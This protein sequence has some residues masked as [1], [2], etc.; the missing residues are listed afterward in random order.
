MHVCLFIC[1]CSLVPKLHTVY[2]TGDLF[3]PEDDESD[4]SVEN[5]EWIQEEREEFTLHL[6]RDGDSLLDRDEVRRWIIPDNYDHVEEEAKHLLQ[7]ADENQVCP[8][9]CV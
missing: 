6:D 5:K 3:D 7:E 8:H 1:T 4:D 9:V 2:N